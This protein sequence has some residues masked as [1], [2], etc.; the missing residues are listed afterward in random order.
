[1]QLSEN[2][3]DRISNCWFP[4]NLSEIC[5]AFFFFCLWSVNWPC[6]TFSTFSKSK[7]TKLFVVQ[8]VWGIFSGW[9]GRIIIILSFRIQILLAQFFKHIFQ[10]YIHIK[11]DQVSLLPLKLK[12]D[13]NNYSSTSHLSN[14]SHVVRPWFNNVK[15]NKFLF[16]IYFIVT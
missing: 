13:C 10:Y 6:G 5:V 12:S 1:M 16:F 7:T 2:V 9:F 15:C 4:W 8:A 14:Q 11:S 3:I